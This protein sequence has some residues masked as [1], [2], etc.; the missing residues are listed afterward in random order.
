MTT[1]VLF[2]LWW[3]GAVTLASCVPRLHRRSLALRLHPY[4]PGGARRADADVSSVPPGLRHQLRALL[5]A[6][7]ESSASFA[8]LTSAG[9]RE[10]VDERLRLVR[11]PLDG[12]A[13]RVRQVGTCFAALLVAGALLPLSGLPPAVAVVA[14]IGAPVACFVAWEQHLS[15]VAA[16]HRRGIVAELPVVAEHLALLL[17]SGW[18]LAGAIDRIGQRA[19][20]L[21]AAE[22]RSVTARIH[23]GLATTNALAEWAASSRVDELDRLVRVLSLDNAGTDTSALVSAEASLLRDEAHRRLIED[24]ERRAQQVWIPVTV[25]ALVPGTALLAVPFVDAL[26]TFAH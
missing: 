7:G 4:Q 10:T 20:G 14:I 25:A 23:H 3:L 6:A 18:S 9:G 16:A 2:T 15:A 13:F 26:S 21:V 19:H 1:V 11:S 17:A 12:A 24:L 8:T 22:L 5:V